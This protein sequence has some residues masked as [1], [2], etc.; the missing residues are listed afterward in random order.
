[1]S[2]DKTP[3]ELFL[4]FCAEIATFWRRPTSIDIP[5]AEVVF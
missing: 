2:G 4:G 3:V 1:M 5:M